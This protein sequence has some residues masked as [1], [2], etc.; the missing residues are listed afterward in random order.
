MATKLRKATPEGW[1]KATVIR[2]RHRA[3]RKG[4]KFNLTWEDVLPPKLCPVFKKPLLLNT[5]DKLGPYL[6]SVDRLHNHRGYVKGNVRVISLRANMLKKD[7][8]LDELQRL[9]NWM[10]GECVSSR[11]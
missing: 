1:A 5:G 4:K 9:V 3:K 2:L 7:A 6:A 11:Q 10:R 8:T